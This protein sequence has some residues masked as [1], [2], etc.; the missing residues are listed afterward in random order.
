MSR[1]T[2]DI[3]GQRFNRLIAIKFSHISKTTSYWTC[4][5]DCGNK[6]TVQ[7]GNLTC[8]HTASCGCWK[9]EINKKLK[10]NFKHGHAKKHKVSKVYR[11]WLSMYNRCYNTNTINYK[12][13]GKR[14][15]S[16][17]PEW[18]YFIPFL[19]YLKSNNNPGSDKNMYTLAMTPNYSID[20]INNDGNYEP[21]NIQIA[22]MKQQCEPGHKRPISKN[23]IN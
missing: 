21:G 3:T 14:G 20:R 1:P 5:C 4:R 11:M 23:S 8:G 9:K 16:V 22:T 13:Y 17:C 18:H 2:K 19:E 15:I 10:K 6:I 7:R 12:D